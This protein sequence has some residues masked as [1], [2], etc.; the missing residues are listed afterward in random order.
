M[1]A[2][3]STLSLCV[4]SGAAGWFACDWFQ[5]R[6]ELA[7]SEAVTRQLEQSAEKVVAAERRITAT[8]QRTETTSKKL[9]QALSVSDL[10]RCPVPVDVGRLLQ[11]QAESTAGAYS[12]AEARLRVYRQGAS[13]MSGSSTD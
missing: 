4:L 13:T 5:L 6:D 8:V 3:W 9:D 11:R 7:S 12:D 1:A 2:G 10:S